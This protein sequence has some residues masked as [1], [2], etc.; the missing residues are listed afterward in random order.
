[1]GLTPDMM[2]LL[3]NQQ[4]VPDTPD[5]N[6]VPQ[7][8]RS[9]LMGLASQ[10][11]PPPDQQIQQNVQQPGRFKQM[12]MGAL[13]GAS[14]GAFSA[15]GIESPEETKYKQGMLALQQQNQQSLGAERSQN[16][17]E[18]VARIKRMNDM[19][20][21]PNGMQVPGAFAKEYLGYLGKTEAQST[22][23][24]GSIAL[25][26][27]KQSGPLGKAKAAE[28]QAKAELAQ[29]QNDPDSPAYKLAQ[30]KLQWANYMKSQQLV[31]AQRK[32]DFAQNGPTSNMRTQ[33]QMAGAL[34]DHMDDLKSQIADLGSK[35]K[36]GPIAGRWSE[37]MAGKVGEGDPEY[38]SLRTNLGL[39]Q[40][41]MMKAHVGARGSE[42]IMEHFKNLFD[43]GKFS[44]ESLDAALDSA[45]SYLR[46]Y[47][48]A[49]SYN[50]GGGATDDN[51]RVYQGHTYKRKG[52][53]QPWIQQ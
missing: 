19:V 9:P 53:G 3:A 37:F 40:T 7:P 38:A 49:G 11:P 30:Q 6:S 12:L 34:L 29:A 17:A 33:G 48:K 41:A 32:A 27:L 26:T 4:Q 50:P 13:W 10:I 46:T 23:N 18:S 25:E 36:L 35:G 44:P 43:G 28:L 5:P 8:R 14:R 47:Q 51:T 16:M 2:G 21:L 42:K 1:M 15:A 20:T 45:A 24:E 52:P 22:K 31:L 39:F